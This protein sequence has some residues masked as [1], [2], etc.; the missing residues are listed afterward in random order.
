MPE[1]II[2][3]SVGAVVLIFLLVILIRTLAFRPKK[4]PPLE[5][6]AVEYDG[7]RAVDSLAQ[8]IRCKTVSHADQSLDDEKEFIKF[9]E[10]LPTLFPNVYKCCELE[11]VTDRA[12]LFRWRGKSESSPTVLMA[13]FDVVSVVEE[14]W[15]KPAFE[16]ICENGVI[17][18]R[19]V[20]DTKGSLNAILCAAEQLISEGFI[21]EN[22]I[23]FAFGGNEEVNGNAAPSIVEKFRERGINPALVLDEG[24]AVVRDVF[25]GVKAPCAVVG[26]AEKGMINVEY[27]VNG[28]GGHSSAPL[29]N[30][31]IDRLSA[32]CVRLSKRPFKF[33]LTKPTLQM[34]DTL[35]RHSTFVYRMIF[36]NLWCFA[37][38][39]NLITKK[40]G[41]QINAIARTTLAF[42]QMEGSKGINVIPPYAKMASNSRIVPGETTDTVLARIRKTVKDENVEIKMING[43]NPSVISRTDCD[44]WNRILDTV[45][46]TWSDAIVSPYLMTACS[47][48]RHWGVIS[49]KVYRFSPLTLSKEENASVHGNNEKVSIDAV[50]RAVEFY[51]RLMKKS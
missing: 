16:G 11:E 18:G 35:G 21:P 3:L 24:G 13:H 45:A 46:S 15:E 48:S 34:F 28:G 27:S 29:P 40:S 36:A 6:L 47:D 1:L 42:T 2:G 14:M 20:I 26:I 39:L 31:P 32:A 12:L 4:R 30:T 17:W 49:D 9:K 43:M 51:I 41:G 38:V 8:M 44:G 22:D 50:K 10:L 23:Y 19:G 7:E 37:P 5:K 33:T 25:P